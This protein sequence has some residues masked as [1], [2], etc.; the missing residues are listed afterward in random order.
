MEHGAFAV[1]EGCCLIVRPSWMAT[2]PLLWQ[3]LSLSWMATFAGSI[4]G[5]VASL[6]LACWQLA[7]S[8]IPTFDD[9]CWFVC[10]G[11]SCLLAAN[12]KLDGYI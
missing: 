10:W 6:I 3:E 4:A 5:S 1:V 2:D 9:S 11:V 12:P 7:P 8:W